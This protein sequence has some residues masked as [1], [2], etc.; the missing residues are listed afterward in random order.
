MGLGCCAGFS[1]EAG[2]FYVN[3]QQQG[4][5]RMAVVL[6][7]DFEDWIAAIWDQGGTETPNGQPAEAVFPSVAVSWYLPEEE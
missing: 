5:A 6:A 3:Y 7:W 4:E 1:D 2:P